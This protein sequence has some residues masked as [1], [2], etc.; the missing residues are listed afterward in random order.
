[1]DAF[2]SSYLKRIRFSLRSVGAWPNHVFEDLPTSKLAA[3]SRYGY[4]SF[5]CTLCCI[6][7]VAQAMYFVNNKGIL[8]FIDLGQSC[9]TLLL[10]LVYIQRTT[11]PIQ[12]AYQETIKE[13]VL[14]FNLIHHKHTTDFSAKMYD[15]VNKICEIT[16]IVAH[17]QFYMSAF[18]FN[19]APLCLNYRAG[20]FSSERPVNVTF[21]HSVYYALPFDQNNGIWFTIIT[22]HNA[23]VSYNLACNFA[24]H[25]LLICLFV[26]HIWGHLTIVEHNLNCFPRPRIHVG[27]KIV[28]L[29]YSNEENK[30]VAA[31]LKEIIKYYIMIKQFITKTSDTYSVTLCVYLGFH[32][33]SDCIL[34][35]ECSTLEVEALAK[36]GVLTLVIYQ[37]LIQ[38]SVVFELISSKSDCLPDAVYGVPWECMDDGNRRSVLILLQIV[39]QPMPLKA[40]GMVPIGVQTML[41]ILK[42]SFSY[43]LMLRTFANN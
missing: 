24:C 12:T 21:D 33:V 1:M 35:L 36:Y 34:L 30:E 32:L 28:P 18:M 22:V 19:L 43:F 8:P 41:A 13:F 5:L 27:S 17:I 25:D 2:D 42:T 6:G 16:S 37:L 26:F 20:M 9:V 29:R 38:L 3:I 15:K 7:V 31:E 14:K 40:C 23:Y 39:Q 4:T 10:C 11:L